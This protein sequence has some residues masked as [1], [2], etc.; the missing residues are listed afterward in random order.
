MT[1]LNG[2]NGRHKKKFCRSHSIETK[3]VRYGP[4]N[5]A[6]VQPVDRW[7]MD[8][9]PMAHTRSYNIP[10]DFKLGIQ[11]SSRLTLEFGMVVV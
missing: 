9:R 4:H 10:L 1:W 6:L 2:T 5:T 3:D 7:H 11:L 8:M